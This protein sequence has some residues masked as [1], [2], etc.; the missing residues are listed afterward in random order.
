[1]V[2][3]ANNHSV[4]SPERARK[5]RRKYGCLVKSSQTNIN[6]MLLEHKEAVF[7]KLLEEVVDWRSEKIKPANGD[8]HSPTKAPAEQEPRAAMTDGIETTNPRLEISSPEAVGREKRLSTPVKDHSISI[9]EETTSSRGLS[10]SP[11][12]TKYESPGRMPP[13]GVF[14]VTTPDRTIR[15]SKDEQS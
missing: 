12:P 6:D 9:K 5:I 11:N 14:S 1:M 2:F 15:D 7:K 10:G 3:V 13:L 4:W 8:V